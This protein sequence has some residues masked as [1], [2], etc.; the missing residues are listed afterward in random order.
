MVISIESGALTFVGKC[1]EAYKVELYRVN[2]ERNEL[3][4]LLQGELFFAA[5]PA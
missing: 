1:L 2:S 4:N 5:I 3:R